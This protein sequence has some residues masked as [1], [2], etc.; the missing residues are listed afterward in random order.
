MSALRG[1]G[2]VAL[3]CFHFSPWGGGSVRLFSSVSFPFFLSGSV[4]CCSS[5]PLRFCTVPFSL[6]R[7]S[8]ASHRTTNDKQRDV[9]CFT[10]PFHL[11]EC[12]SGLPIVTSH[13]PKTKGSLPLA[14]QAGN[15]LEKPKEKTCLYSFSGQQ[16]RVSG[17][18]G[19]S[20][21]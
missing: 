3:P 6:F 11:T 5:H 4:P 1:A 12:Y 10:A 17:P 9:L 21:H 7:S 8:R 2:C 16:R 19:V 14:Q 18:A 13:Q 15:S 20:R